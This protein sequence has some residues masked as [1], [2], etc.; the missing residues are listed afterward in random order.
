[1]KGAP[2][3]HVHQEDMKDIVAKANFGWTLQVRKYFIQPFEAGLSHK[4]TETQGG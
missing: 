4:A 3:F 2:P 1:M